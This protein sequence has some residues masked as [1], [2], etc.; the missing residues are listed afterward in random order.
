MTPS[1]VLVLQLNFCSAHLVS[2]QIGLESGIALY[3]S[4]V[5]SGHFIDIIDPRSHKDRLQ[6]HVSLWH[7][8]TDLL[9][10]RTSKD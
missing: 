1:F 3:N 4:F 6:H 2:H 5:C 9:A 7:V 10:A 8:T